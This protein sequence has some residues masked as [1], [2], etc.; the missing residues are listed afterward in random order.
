[1]SERKV[2]LV[3][4]SQVWNGLGSCL[5]CSL[6]SRSA[7]VLFRSGDR[8]RVIT[9]RRVGGEG[10]AGGGEEGRGS[11]AEARTG[12]GRGGAKAHRSQCWPLVAPGLRY[13]G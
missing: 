1:M 3:S 13:A 5:C 10:K 8:T 9:G 12:I 4:V 6:A 11:N 7:A 2:A